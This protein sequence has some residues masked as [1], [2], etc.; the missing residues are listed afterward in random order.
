MKINFPE[1]DVLEFDG[2]KEHDGYFYLSIQ[3]SIIDSPIKYSFG[4][5]NIIEGFDGNKII[6]NAG[7][8]EKLSPERW[9]KLGGILAKFMRSHNILNLYLSEEIINSLPSTDFSVLFEGFFLGNYSFEYF[10][11]ELPFEKI[12]LMFE[13]E[14]MTLKNEVEKIQKICSTIN[15]ARELGQ[16]PGNVINPHSLAEICFGLAE[17][18]NLKLKILDE[19]DLEQ[20]GAEA[21]L[22]VGKGSA[23]PPRLIVLEYNAE[24][25][26]HEK[27]II[28]VGKAITFD[29]GGYSIKTGDGI[30]GMKFDKMGGITV[31]ATILAAS[32]LEIP[33]NVVGI[34]CAA[35]NM[36]SHEA[37]RPDDI[38]KTLSGKTVEILSTDAEGRLILADGL[39]YAQRNFQPQCI[40]DFATLTGG[41]VTALGKIRAGLFSNNS[42]LS[43]KLFK[44]GET[45]FERLWPM[46]L[47]DDYFEFIKGDDADLKNSGGREGHPIMGGIFL[48]QFIETDVPWAHIDI[49]GTAI[50]TKSEN[51]QPKGANGFGIRLMLDYLNN[52]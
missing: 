11:K 19:K 21:I 13:S 7:E 23:S 15:Y 43:D 51:Y 17:K 6:L 31:L 25:S 9:R 32:M 28:M 3:Y 44:S 40:I 20:I 4:D 22:S 10:K 49:A 35:E 33:K 48:K 12:N 38:I 45:T 26:T 52:L 37:Y 34:I 47:D 36:I 16:L 24:K 5:I 29:T 41:I 2:T 46:P 50:S 39:T 1:L 27:P 42:D 8:I 18:Y 30:K 14:D